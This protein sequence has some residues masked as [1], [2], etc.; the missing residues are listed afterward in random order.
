MANAFGR[1]SRAGIAATAATSAV[2]ATGGVSPGLAPL[3]DL[4]LD[5]SGH[6]ARVT[7]ATDVNTVRFRNMKPVAPYSLQEAATTPLSALDMPWFDRLA[8]GTDVMVA[9]VSPNGSIVVTKID[10][11]MPAAD[12]RGFV[13]ALGASQVRLVVSNEHIVPT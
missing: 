7:S 1:R 2:L 12:Q 13:T 5:A 4:Y 10:P 6:V 3:S 11:Q 9:T 8:P